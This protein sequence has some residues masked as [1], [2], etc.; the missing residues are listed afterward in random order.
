MTIILDQHQIYI[1]FTAEPQ[2]LSGA[3]DDGTV[4]IDDDLLSLQHYRFTKPVFTPIYDYENSD[5]LAL[6]RVGT[7]PPL[8]ILQARQQFLPVLI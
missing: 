4:S 7:A 8:E 1:P 3:N 6:Y 5:D 2:A